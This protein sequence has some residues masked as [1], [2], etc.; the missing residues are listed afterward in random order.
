MNSSAAQTIPTPTATVRSAKTVKANVITQTATSVAANVTVVVGTAVAMV[1]LSWRLALI[2]LVVLPPAVL[3]TRQVARMR[4]R[5]TGERQRAAGRDDQVDVGEDRPVGVVR[6]ADGLEAHLA[7]GVGTRQPCGCRGLGDLDREVG[8][9]EDP[10]EQR[11]RRGEVDTDVEQA[12]QW[13]EQGALQGHEGDERADRG[14]AL[15]RLRR[16]DL[17]PG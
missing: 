15:A 17:D 16:H 4:H 10:A 7:A 9:L 1:A 2:S 6:E 8:V 13:S 12:R 11:H 14:L 5:V 3:L